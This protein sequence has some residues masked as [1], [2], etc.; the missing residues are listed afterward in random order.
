MFLLRLSDEGH[1]SNEDA[2]AAL[3]LVKLKLQ[4]ELNKF[5]IN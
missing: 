5:L 3:E 2:K 1:D 4:E